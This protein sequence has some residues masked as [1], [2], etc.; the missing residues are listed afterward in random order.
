MCLMC[1][2]C[3]P[4]LAVRSAPRDESEKSEVRASA[5]TATLGHKE[6]MPSLQQQEKNSGC[7]C[8]NFEGMLS[9]GN[10]S[11]LRT[12]FKVKNSAAEKAKEI[13]EEKWAAAELLHF[14]F[15][16]WFTLRFFKRTVFPFWQHVF[17]K[18]DSHHRN[19]VE[20]FILPF[21]L[22][23]VMYSDHGSEAQ[24]YYLYFSNYPKI[25]ESVSRQ[26]RGSK[27]K[28]TWPRLNTYIWP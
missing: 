3:G 5:N 2:W 28:D 23:I 6:P 13:S 21:L 20:V 1:V 17:H 22:V 27:G 8:L 11:C 15:M 14:L 18:N 12:Y 26:E 9:A 25:R 24:L 10:G 19:E 4:A 7:G 16:S